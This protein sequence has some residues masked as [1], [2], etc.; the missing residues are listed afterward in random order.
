M[1]ASMTAFAR[2]QAEYDWGTLVW[3]IR[4]V[5]HRYL[6]PGIRIPD[7]L[8]PIEPAV[9]ESLRK[10]ISRGKVDCQVRFQV[11]HQDSGHEELNMA[12]VERLASLSRQITDLGTGAAPLSAADI[13]RWPGALQEE[14][15][16]LD[17]MQKD[18]LDLLAETAAELAY[19]MMLKPGDI[20]L[21]NSH[22][23][24]HARAAFEDDAASGHARLLHR[25]WLTMP[26]SRALPADHAVLWKNIAAGARRGGI[27][28]T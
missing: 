3:E 8:K 2:K 4:S 23:T 18:A 1:V 27:A 25:L 20:Q 26:N 14:E 12:L 5:N 13:L 19:A 6:E 10:A 7:S 22:I 11:R 21:I 15:I 16:D 17:T 24:Y 28:V 9:R